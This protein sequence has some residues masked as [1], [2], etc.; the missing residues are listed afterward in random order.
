MKSRSTVIGDC[1]R[2]EESDDFIIDEASFRESCFGDF[3]TK[4]CF[5]VG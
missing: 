5:E 3:A 1:L 2:L 4:N